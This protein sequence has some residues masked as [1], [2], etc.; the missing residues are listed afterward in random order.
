MIRG[1]IPME[2][3]KSIL[4]AA[5]LTLAAL[6]AFA[7]VAPAQAKDGKF[8]D[9]FAGFGT[10]KGAPVGKERLLTTI[11]ENDLWISDD[12]MFDH[13]TSHCSGLGDFTKSEGQAHGFCVVTD[14]AGDQ[15]VEYF[16]TG[17]FRL[18]QKSMNGSVTLKGGA[19]KFAGIT[20]TGTYVYDGNSCKPT[21]NGTYFS[22][23]VGHISYKLP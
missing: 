5:T 15:L 3:C 14:P 16:V 13:L 2:A 17:K 23:G 1:G 10:F 21:E 19:G 9:S 22:H 11:E 7:T 8:T 4:S 18:G 20:G 6:F 12:P